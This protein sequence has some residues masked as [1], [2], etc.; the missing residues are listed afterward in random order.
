M[1]KIYQREKFPKLGNTDIDISDGTFTAECG[2]KGYINENYDA[3]VEEHCWLHKDES[4]Y[5]TDDYIHLFKPKEG[6]K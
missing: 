5:K 6:E 1:K 3:V 4:I 2:C